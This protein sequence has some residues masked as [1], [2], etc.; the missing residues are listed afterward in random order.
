MRQNKRRESGC[1]TCSVVDSDTSL[2]EYESE[3]LVEDEVIT[4]DLF[5]ARE[6]FSYY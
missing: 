2:P 1:R 4:G 5:V 6:L 3:E